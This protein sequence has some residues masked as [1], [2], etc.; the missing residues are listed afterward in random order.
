MDFDLDLAREQS[1][2]NPYYYVMYAY[3]RAHS[4]LAKAEERKLRPA[5]GV[6]K[7]GDAELALV[8]AMSRLP[9][10]IVE[11]AEDYGVHRLTFYGLELAKLFTEFYDSERIIDLPENDAREKLYFVQQFVVFMDVYWEL[12]GIE[13]QRRMEQK[14]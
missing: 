1:A 9:E 3:A 5:K 7:L 8:R 4:I 6:G 13:P 12:L 10:M 2:K 14:G 11:M